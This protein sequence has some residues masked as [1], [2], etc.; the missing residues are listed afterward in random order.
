MQVIDLLSG[1]MTIQDLGSVGEF[2]A[3]I[4]T[5]VTLAYL[6]FQIR[7]STKVARAQLTKD[8][9]SRFAS[10]HLWI[11]C[12]NTSARQNCWTAFFVRA[13]G[14]IIGR[15]RGN[16]AGILMSTVDPDLPL[17]DST[18]ARRDRAMRGVLHSG[19]TVRDTRSE[20]RKEL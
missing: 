15:L 8:L 3:A 17:Y 1:V 9:F 10:S 20:N 6:S 14:V 5:L 13:D 4:A 2:V 11:S 19:D 18:R 12:S 16:T 7:Q